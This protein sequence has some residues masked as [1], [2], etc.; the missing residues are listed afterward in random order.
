MK[1]PYII[2]EIGF[3]HEG[4]MDAAR[5]MIRAAAGA[6]ANAVKFQTFLASDLA[7]PCSSHF[8]LVKPAEMT[9]DDLC[10]LKAWADEAGV[11]FLSTPFSVQAVKWLDEIDVPAVKIAS[12]DCTNLHLL[13]HVAA[14]SRR[15]LISTGMAD[16]DEIRRTLN[17]LDEQGSGE[18]VILHCISN[19]P[20]RAEELNLAVLGLLKRTFN[21]PV[22]YSDHHHNPQACLLAAILGAEIIETHFTIFPERKDGDHAHSLGPRDLERLV[23]DINTACV[24]IG[25]EKFMENRSDRENA[26][27][28]R[29]GLYAGKNLVKGETIRESDMLF[30]RPV[31][32]MSPSDMEGINGKILSRN[33]KQYTPLMHEDVESNHG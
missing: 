8:T 16:M 17:F 29:R 7:L 6:G 14:T 9:F 2:A 18:V 11:D 26:P 1:P 4:N 24:M 19:Y 25:S 5:Q 3:N 22:G 10:T 21:R 12:M 23:A 31:S 27:V 15:I 32:S 13:K 33:V 30:C 20:A 28:F